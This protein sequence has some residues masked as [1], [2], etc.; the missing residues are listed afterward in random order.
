MTL[1]DPNPPAAPVWH[2]GFRYRV[3]KGH[4]WSNQW[5]GHECRDLALPFE[6]GVR[7]FHAGG[8]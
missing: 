8:R 4:R 5:L 3:K 6:V 7:A 1:F 2:L